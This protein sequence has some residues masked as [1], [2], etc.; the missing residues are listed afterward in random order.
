MILRDHLEDQLA[1]LLGNSPTTPDSSSHFAEHGPIQFEACLVPP[2]HGFRQGEHE[3][4]LPLRPEGA[5]YNPEQFV[6]RTE[7]WPGMLAFQHRE[8]L[9]EGEVFQQQAAASAKDA[10]QGS[11]PSRKS[12]NMVPRL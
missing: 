7:L 5:N 10:I 8:L 2:N 9:A 3:C 12:S 6:E 11:E 1:Y 4:V